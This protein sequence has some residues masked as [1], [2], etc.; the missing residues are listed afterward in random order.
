MDFRAGRET[1]RNDHQSHG[2][3]ERAARCSTACWFD[4]LDVRM[5]LCK[6]I[7]TAY[8]GSCAAAEKFKIWRIGN[9]VLEVLYLIQLYHHPSYMKLCQ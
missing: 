5:A 7:P 8:L 2:V 1:R 6:G 3:W 4:D 9:V